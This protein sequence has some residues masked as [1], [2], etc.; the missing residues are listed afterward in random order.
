MSTSS[1]R[2][3]EPLDLP[4]EDDCP[5][6]RTGAPAW[7]WV[8]LGVCGVAAIGAAMLCTG[9][10]VW[11]A[12]RAVDEG[13]DPS[14]AKRGDLTLR[15]VTVQHPETA[16]AVRVSVSLSDFWIEAYRNSADT[17][18]SLVLTD[19]TRRTPFRAW[20]LKDSAD[21]RRIYALCKDGSSRWMTLKILRVGPDGTPTKPSGYGCAVVG[22][23]DDR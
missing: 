15:E 2:D 13:A 8:L 10:V 11:V 14:A 22:I 18:Y 17:H 23:V 1:E 3:D 20:V 16:V 6:R 19:A 12:T 9:A 7:A 21:G 4:D 5:P